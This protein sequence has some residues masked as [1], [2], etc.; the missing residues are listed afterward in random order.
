[1]FASQQHQQKKNK[2]LFIIFNII[3]IKAQHLSASK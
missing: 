1:M 2:S 3:R